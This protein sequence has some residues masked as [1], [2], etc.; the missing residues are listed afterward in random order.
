MRM[1]MPTCPQSP[2]LQSGRPPA[3]RGAKRLRSES[4]TR[5]SREAVKRTKA[6][7]LTSALFAP[8]GILDSQTTD[9]QYVRGLGDGDTDGPERGLCSRGTPRP[10]TP[11]PPVFGEPSRPAPTFHSVKSSGKQAGATSVADDEPVLLPS[12]ELAEALAKESLGSIKDLLLNLVEHVFDNRIHA[13]E[14][15][16]DEEWERSY[17][18]RSDNRFMTATIDELQA[19][20]ANCT[21]NSMSRFAPTL[22]GSQYPGSPTPSASS[23]V[24][25]EY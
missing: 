6:L 15:R 3:S 5:S 7:N 1:T 22:P 4:P 9:S 25:D 17:M 21:C 8:G 14:K 24:A 11:S 12:A 10:R 18:L 13:L 19:T 2:Q 20:L 23:R 16:L